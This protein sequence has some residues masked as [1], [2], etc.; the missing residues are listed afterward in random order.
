MEDELCWLSTHSSLYLPK[1]LISELILALFNPFSPFSHSYPYLSY[2]FLADYVPP[3]LFSKV[4]KPAP[5]GES[6]T[7]ESNRRSFKPTFQPPPKKSKSSKASGNKRKRKANDDDDDDFEDE[8]EEEDDD[9]PT[10]G[11]DKYVCIDGKQRLSS[12]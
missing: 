4:Q 5:G 10:S 2:P 11:V 12:M 1:S 7:A 8:E 9:E 6:K 3:I